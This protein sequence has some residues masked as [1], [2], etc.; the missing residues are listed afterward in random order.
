MSFGRGYHVTCPQCSAVAIN[1]APCH[2][3]GCRLVREEWLKETAG[4]K[5]PVCFPEGHP[6]TH[7]LKNEGRHAK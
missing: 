4:Y 5:F 7:L 3:S 1:G 2:E 6:P